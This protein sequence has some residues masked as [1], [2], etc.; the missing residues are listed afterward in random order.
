MS[1]V[2]HGVSVLLADHA[3]PLRDELRELASWIPNPIQSFSLQSPDVHFHV[4]S[5]FSSVLQ[6]EIAFPMLTVR[7]RQTFGWKTG[8]GDHA[9][10][11]QFDLAM[12]FVELFYRQF[13]ILLG[14]SVFPLITVF[15]FIGQSFP[16]TVYYFRFGI[17][18]DD[19]GS[20]SVVSSF[21][22]FLSWKKT[23]SD[24]SGVLAGQV[25]ND[26]S[27]WEALLPTRAAW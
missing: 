27:L 12:E 1:A 11:Q 17:I 10:K 6:L 20:D 7:A 8:R 15:G 26:Q 5:S 4:F 25:A 19:F 16:S 14:M 3:G 21:S 13:V 9:Q 18:V 24:G 22:F 23:N 2:R